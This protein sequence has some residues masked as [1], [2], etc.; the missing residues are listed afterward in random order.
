[1]E[2]PHKKSF[3]KELLKQRQKKKPTKIIVIAVIVM[4]IAV[5]YALYMHFGE[6][7]IPTEETIV[8]KPSI[9]VLSFEDFSKEGDLE[10]LCD[11]MAEDIIN[12]LSTLNNKLIVI[13]RETSFS[14][15]GKENP[16]GEIAK[17]INVDYVLEGSIQ[18]AGN[19]LRI[20]AQLIK[21]ADHSHVFSM[22]FN[23]EFNEEKIFAMQDSI[24]LAIV[25][26]LKIKLLG[27]EKVAVEK[28]YTE[29]IKAYNLY[30]NGI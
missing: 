26:A 10:Y 17:A 13:A 15:K 29:N 23:K 6:R 24:S 7:E 20:T 5:G 30:R 25:D 4:L 21:S 2:Y 3:S 28:R 12:K 18:K 9:A 16:I 1:M 11:G 8:E 27:E 19:I 22:P 14:F